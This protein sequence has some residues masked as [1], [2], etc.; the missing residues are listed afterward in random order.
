MDV[1]DAVGV[2]VE[3]DLDLRH[4]ARRRGDAD[5][6]ELAEQLVVRRH[7]A[8]ALEHADRHRLLVVLGGRV[9]LRLLGRDR[10]V[11]VDHAGEHAAER[12][13]AERQRGHVE[14]QHVLDVALQHACLD[15]RAHRHDL[16][17][18]DADV[19]FLA[20]ELLHRL[21]HLGHAGHAADEHDVVD[22]RGLEAGIGERLLHRLLG[23]LDQ[24]GD[25]LLEVRAGDRLDEVQ[26][27]GAAAFHARGDERQVDLGGRGRGE[28]D[29][30]LFGRFLEALKSE[31]VGL[32]VHVL[33][34]LEPVGQPLD[35]LAVEVLAAEEGVAVGRLHLEHA[36]ADLEDRDVE[37][38][39]AE[40]V[41]R[42]RL[43][44]VLLEAVGQSGRG[45]LVDDAQHF[46]AG[47]LSGV[48]GR[49]ALRVVEVRGHG[50][51]RLG[52]GLAEIG[53]GSFLHLL[54]DEGADL[55]RRV[56]LAAGLDPRVAVLALDDRVRDQ[57][58][59]L[60]GHRIVEP[61]ADQALDREDRV[62]AVGDRL[63][64][65]RLADQALAVLGEG[66]DR[67]RGARAFR[68]LDD[69]GLAPSITA[70][71]LLVV[72]RSIPITLAI[73]FTPH[74]FRSWTPPVRSPIPWRNRVGGSITRRI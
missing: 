36:V 60:L 49:L 24:V 2:D 18:V 31:L 12:L 66:D 5:Q 45:R 40:V 20:E 15:R 14:Q 38:A 41:D 26:R 51:H 43:A 17:G 65:G 11:A 29:L 74:P 1:D 61:A 30:G 13:D 35:E 32:Q 47:D 7:L 58:G 21:A 44:V 69:L 56:V 64:L 50:D 46:E 70:T 42:D 73:R 4:A 10:G 8:L 9:D 16:V 72:P 48:L 53:L 67:R 39:A 34:G 71:Q 6:V 59:V 22:V 57:L 54:Q 19:R 52:D 62:V 55:A 25:H 27:G 63:A 33:L 28:L 68:I 3:G 23:A 37:R